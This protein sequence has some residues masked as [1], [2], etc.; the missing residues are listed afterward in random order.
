V[1]VDGSG[2]FLV[3][4]VVHVFVSGY[5]SVFVAFYV[6]FFLSHFAWLL[7]SIFGVLSRLALSLL[8]LPTLYLAHRSLYYN[9][10]FSKITFLLRDI[11]MLGITMLIL[12]LVCE[13][14]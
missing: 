1:E 2:F 8:L 12:F 11:S 4:Y 14:V 5:S 3:S 13:S 6:A 9:R 7:S 10:L